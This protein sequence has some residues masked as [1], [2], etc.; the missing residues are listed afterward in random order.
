MAG[1]G[2]CSAGSRSSS[3]ADA[4]RML[5]LLL[6]SMLERK[7]HATGST[8]GTTK[9]GH[10]STTEAE[11]TEADTETT[12][13]TS[14]TAEVVA[15]TELLLLL[16]QLQLESAEFV[17]LLLHHSLEGVAIAAGRQMGRRRRGCWRR[18]TTSGHELLQLEHVTREARRRGGGAGRRQ[19]GRCQCRMMSTTACRQKLG[20]VGRTEEGGGGG[21]VDLVL[22][23]TQATGAGAGSRGSSLGREQLLPYPLALDERCQNCGVA[24]SGA[25]RCGRSNGR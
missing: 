21:R 24:V 17:L 4:R 8:D 23:T 18:G 6:L 22:M 2:S 14:T 15:K 5:Q 16:V 25:G 9:S 10:A 11:A 20:V 19:A 1:G 12:E 13:R 3:D 7:G